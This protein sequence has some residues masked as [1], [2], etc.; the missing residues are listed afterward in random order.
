MTAQLTV[1]SSPQANAAGDV[2]QVIASLPVSLHPAS[3]GQADVAAI[4]G[5]GAW[6]D[7]A[8]EALASG[9]HGLLIIH[10][11]PGDVAGLAAR[12]KAA[13]VP[14]VIDTTWAYNPAVAAAAEHFA[15]R[16]D[17]DSLLEARVNAPADSDLDQVLLAQLALVRAAV[18]PVVNLTYARRNRHGYDALADLAGGARASLSAILTDSVRKSA[19]LRIITPRTAVTL[20]VPGPETA[21]PGTVTVSGPE[22]AT[23]L[24]TSYETAHRVAW[25]HLHRLV[26]TRTP[27]DD[28]AGFAA[29]LAAATNAR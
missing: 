24:T 18:A 12:A 29:D 17:T 21:A 4:S 7:T 5:T 3:D 14:V 19:T 26:E 13:Q 9:T 11:S 27:S 6:T 23:L 1:T 15:A 25:R 20:T 2:A 28:L 16:Y 8:L 22:G 10:P